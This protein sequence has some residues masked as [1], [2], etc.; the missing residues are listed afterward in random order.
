MDFQAS[1]EVGERGANLVD[2]SRRRE[3]AVIHDVDV[4]SPPVEILRLMGLVERFMRGSPFRRRVNRHADR[5]VEGRSDEDV[6]VQRAPREVF[7]QV[8]R[9]EDGRALVSPSPFEARPVPP[10]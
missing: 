9:P 7:G 1:V 6:A 4:G 8:R 5:P 2:L 10:G 3:V